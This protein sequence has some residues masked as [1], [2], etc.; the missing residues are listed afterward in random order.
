[1]E[2]M[3]CASFCTRRQK[4]TAGK[5][6]IRGPPSQLP[7]GSPAHSVYTSDR[8]VKQTEKPGVRRG[9]WQADEEEQ[10]GRWYAEELKGI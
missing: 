6:C 5:A 4:L 3:L 7:L 9:C 10:R 1:M 8:T 2:E